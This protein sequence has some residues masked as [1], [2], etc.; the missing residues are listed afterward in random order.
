MSRSGRQPRWG[1]AFALNVAT[2]IVVNLDRDIRFG[3]LVSLRMFSLLTVME[4]GKRTMVLVTIGEPARA[5][6][7]PESAR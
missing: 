4:L 6:R 1:P 5:T 3:M 2:E 7:R